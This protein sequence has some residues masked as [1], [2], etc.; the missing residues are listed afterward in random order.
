MN[1]ARKTARVP[2]ACGADRADLVGRE[3]E[4]D[5][6]RQP[7]DEQQHDEAD[8]QEVVAELLGGDDP[9]ARGQSRQGIGLHLGRDRR[10]LRRGLGLSGAGA[11]GGRRL[12]AH[13][14]VFPPAIA[15]S[16][17]PRRWSAVR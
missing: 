9:P 11:A 12:G 7:E 5:R 17:R 4:R 14:A 13:A 6:R 10:R 3:V 1:S 16:A 15:R 8:A 2:L